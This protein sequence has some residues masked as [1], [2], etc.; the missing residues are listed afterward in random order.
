[1]IFTIFLYA[2][3][4]I[5]ASVVFGTLALA[6]AWWAVKAVARYELRRKVRLA[7]LTQFTGH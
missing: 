6:F 4:L 1:M 7:A 5:G 2:F 3:A